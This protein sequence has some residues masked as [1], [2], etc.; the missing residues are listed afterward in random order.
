MPL[1]KVARLDFLG[2]Y[3]P[4]LSVYRVS[5]NKDNAKRLT[6]LH[7]MKMKICYEPCFIDIRFTMAT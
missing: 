5:I 4:F 3:L 6:R 2:V 1:I 7:C